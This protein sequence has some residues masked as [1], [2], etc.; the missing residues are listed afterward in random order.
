[1][2]VSYPLLRIG[3]QPIGMRSH[4]PCAQEATKATHTRLHE[5]LNSPHRAHRAVRHGDCVR[6]SGSVRVDPC[7]DVIVAIKGLEILAQSDMRSLDLAFLRTS[8]SHVTCPQTR[9]DCS[10]VSSLS[11]CE[12]DLLLSNLFAAWN[13]QLSPAIWILSSRAS[14]NRS[15]RGYT[16]T[17][18]NKSYEEL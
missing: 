7:K 1:V 11:F 16:E 15:R 3:D 12:V 2:N 6:H 10:L 5:R 17:R 13:Q 4:Q 9:K 8:S 18:C 14:A